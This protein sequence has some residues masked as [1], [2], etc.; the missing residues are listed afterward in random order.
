MTLLDYPEHVGCTVFLGGCDLR[1]PYC[2]NYELALRKVPP[3]MDENEFFSFLERRKGLLDAVT[4]SGG[5][6]CLDAGLPELLRRIRQMGYKVKLDTNGMHP[7]RLAEVT[8][9]G[10]VDYVAMDIKNS[11]EKYAATCG[12]EELDLDRI[13]QSIRILKKGAVDYE[14]RTTVVKEFHS[15]DDFHRIGELIQGAEKYFLQIFTDRDTVPYAG[16]HA[17][18]PE[19]MAGF[20]AVSRLY[21]PAARIRGEE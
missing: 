13:L 19:E 14:F 21:V 18:D 1:C 11:P 16:L 10:L 5:E 9:E 3:V 12:L 15:T 17:P 4:V 8:K 2:H 7:Q 20:L 6:P